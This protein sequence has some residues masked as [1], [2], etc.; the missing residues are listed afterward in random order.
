MT[1]LITSAEAGR[2]LGV[3]YG[4]LAKWRCLQLRALPFVRVG[5]K[6]FYRAQDIEGFI[7]ANT[8]PGDGPRATKK[9][10][11]AQR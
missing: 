10:K 6:I 8:Y 7:A 1:E 4:T 3:T 5:R 11:G 2:R 9:M